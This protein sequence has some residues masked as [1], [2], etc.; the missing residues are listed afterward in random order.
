VQMPANLQTH[1]RLLRYRINATDRAGNSVRV[2]YA[3]DPSPN[4]AYFVYDGVPAWT[5]AVQ[6]GSTP[7]QTF[8]TTTMRKVRAFHLISR[9]NDVWNC[10]YNPGFNDGVYR[11]EGALVIHANIYVNIHYCVNVKNCT[12]NKRENKSNIKFIRRH[13]LEMPNDNANT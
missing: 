6:P 11:F 8:D 13:R 9:S 4:F 10:Q 3:D 5:G 2:P 12:Y 1:R 7:A